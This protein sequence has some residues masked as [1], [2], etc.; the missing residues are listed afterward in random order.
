MGGGTG[1]FLRALAASKGGL[2]GAVLLLA[3]VLLTAAAPLLPVPGPTQ[4]NLRARLQPPTLSLTE[5]GAHPLGTDNIGRDMLSRILHGGQLTLAVGAAAVVLGGVVGVLLGI[6][7]GYRGGMWDRV[8]MRLVDIQLAF[9]LMLLALI[10]AAALGPSV[11]NL[12]IV[13]A[14]TSWT[15]YARIVRGQTLAVRERE[16]VQS[17]RAIA[18]SPWRIM[19]RHILPN[20]MTPA[21]VVATLELARVII[22]EAALSFLGLGVQPPWPS[23]GR[24]LA[25]GRTYMASAW[26]IAAFPGLAIMLTVLSVNLLGDW[27][28]DYFDPKLK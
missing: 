14:L 17:A 28:R 5:I 18:A 15:R 3:F 7:A 6:V 19:T 4:S 8:L 26:W 21:L 13:L 10:I 25:E 27:L 20:V 1:N 2:I 23:W 11:R 16:F 24:M 12:I 22:L 9:P